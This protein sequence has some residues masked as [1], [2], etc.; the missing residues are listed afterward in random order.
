MITKSTF[1]QNVPKYLADHVIDSQQNLFHSTR[2]CM[3]H[4][5]HVNLSGYVKLQN[6]YESLRFVRDV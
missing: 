1:E 5:N 3:F 2:W 4:V 6:P